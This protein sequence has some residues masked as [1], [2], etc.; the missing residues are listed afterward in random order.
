VATHADGVQ[1]DSRPRKAS[2]ARAS[3]GGWLTRV[4]CD[5]LLLPGWVAA[6]Q[7]GEA[8]EADR[9]DAALRPRPTDRSAIAHVISNRPIDWELIGQHYDE[10]VKYAIALKLGTAEAQ[11]LL[12]RFARGGPKHPADQAMEELGRAARTILLCDYLARETVRREVHEGRQVI[13]RWNSGVDFIFYSKDSELTGEDQEI[14]MLAMHL[15][16][17]S[18]VLVNTL[19]I[20]QIL[21]EPSKRSRLTPATR[22]RSP[23]CSGRTSTPTAPSTSTAPRRRASLARTGGSPR[24]ARMPAMDALVARRREAN[25]LGRA[26]AFV[27]RRSSQGKA[28]TSRSGWKRQPG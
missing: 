1:S 14:S 16:Q 26:P 3:C 9:K 8:S 7:R 25:Q 10:L 17:S 5:R 15:L 19:I 27:R 23:P 21:S 22:K 18:L 4:H 11:Q 13:E 20:Q 28:E 6:H 2:G 24:V 12:R